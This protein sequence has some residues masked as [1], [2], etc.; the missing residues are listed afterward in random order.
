MARKLPRCAWC[1]ESLAKRGRICIEYERLPKRPM[2]GWH[3]EHS[4]DPYCAKVDPLFDK[5]VKSGVDKAS[6]KD[7]QNCLLEI[8]DRGPGRV[9]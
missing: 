8:N 7:V 1:G 5:L 2:I 3:T 4:K 6:D 9:S